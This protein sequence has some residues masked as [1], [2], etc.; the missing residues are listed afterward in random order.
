[1]IAGSTRATTGETT[2]VTYCLALLTDTGVVVA[3][4][5]RTSAGPDYLNTVRK[6]HR[7]SLADRHMVIATAGNL[8]TT[9]ETNAELDRAIAD[10]GRESL[11][12]VGDL[13]Q[14]ATHVGQVLRATIDR[15]RMALEADGVAG[16]ASLIVAG[17]IGDGDP[18]ALL[19]YPQGNAISATPETPFLQ[20]GES[21]YGKPMLDRLASTDLGLDEAALLA[22]VSLDATIRS[23]ATVGPPLCIVTLP[24]APGEPAEVV[25][26]EGDPQLIAVRRAWESGIASAFAALPAVVI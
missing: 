4:D 20:I 17:R 19:V 26:D 1:M 14:A 25:L 16:E 13:W 18:G 22:L 24:R 10:A 15:H 2:P 23:N 5:S 3:A 9:Q 21:K 12:T 8:A 11:A 6:L 7:W